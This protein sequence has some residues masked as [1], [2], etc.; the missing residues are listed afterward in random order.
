MKKK[1]ILSSF[2]EKNSIFVR[3]C[4][5]FFILFWTKHVFSNTTKI[6]FFKFYQ[7][8]KDKKSNFSVCGEKKLLFWVLFQ[9]KD[10]FVSIC[11]TCPRRKTFQL[12]NKI[13]RKIFIKKLNHPLCPDRDSSIQNRAYNIQTGSP[14]KTFSMFYFKNTCIRNRKKFR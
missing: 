13:C 9:K 12:K 2:F 6:S 11:L 5:N 10:F 4:F 1:S 3:F 14:E 7:F 8:F